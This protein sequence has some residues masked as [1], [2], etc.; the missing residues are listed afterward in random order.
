MYYIQDH[1]FW[2]FIQVGL[3]NL[4]EVYSLTICA[5]KLSVSQ[6]TPAEANETT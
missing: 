1:K 4:S 6:S 2:S 3:W 5:E